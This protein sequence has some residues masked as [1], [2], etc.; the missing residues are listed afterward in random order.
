M[1]QN[2]T[3]CTPEIVSGKA[4]NHIVPTLV[5]IIYNYACVCMHLSWKMFTL[6]GSGLNLEAFSS[7][8]RVVGYQQGAVESVYHLLDY[9]HKK[10]NDK[11]AIRT[12][13]AYMSRRVDVETT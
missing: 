13:G 10:V 11:L 9:R 5:H 7:T 12:W 3:N 1:K 8:E 2:G 4:A 6:P